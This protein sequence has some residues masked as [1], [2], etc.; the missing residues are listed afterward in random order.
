MRSSIGDPF[1][2]GEI[3]YE[4]LGKLVEM[5]VENSGSIIVAG[6]TSE[7]AT[8]TDEEYHTVVEFVIDRVNKRIP[9]IA[10]AGS[11]YYTSCS[12]KAQFCEE[13]GS[14]RPIDSNS[15]LQQNNSKRD[16]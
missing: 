2:D 10:G 7:A 16:L 3:D 1:A 6:T 13:A 9:V 4:V 12:K 15:L 5:H 14:R 11:N 8:M